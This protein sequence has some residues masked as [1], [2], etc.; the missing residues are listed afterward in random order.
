MEEILDVK[1]EVTFDAVDPFSPM[2]SFHFDRLIEVICDRFPLDNDEVSHG[3]EIVSLVVN[4]FSPFANGC[5]HLLV[6]KGEEPTYDRRQYQDEPHHDSIGVHGWVSLAPCFR[7]YDGERVL[8]R[9]G[10]ALKKR[11]RGQR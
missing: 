4:D 8:T 10:R 3:V 11:A 5:S 7:Y 2:P 9:F 6:V 1:R